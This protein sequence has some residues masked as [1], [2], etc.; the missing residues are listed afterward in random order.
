M[1]QYSWREELSSSLGKVMRPVAEIHIKDKNNIWRA[2]T[3]YIDSG[4]DISILKKS[5]GELFGHNVE[6]GRKIKLK[7]VG[8]DE[9]TAYLHTMDMLIGAHE[10]KIEAAI[11]ENDDVPHILGRKDVFN[12][13]EIQFKNKDKATH[14]IA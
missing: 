3:M 13:F 2:I 1:T 5:H 7:G 14:F 6:K 9:I 10:V 8:K 12:H 4:A 11:A